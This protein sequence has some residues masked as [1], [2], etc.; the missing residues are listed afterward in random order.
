M[1]LNCFIANSIDHDG[2]STAGDHQ[3][4]TAKED[5]QPACSL[6]PGCAFPI[7]R[8][9]DRGGAVALPFVPLHRW[10]CKGTQSRLA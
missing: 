8:A 1:L 5:L 6:P 3:V 7:G 4:H 2:E 10:V 9:R